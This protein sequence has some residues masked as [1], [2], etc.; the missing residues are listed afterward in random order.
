MKRGLLGTRGG[1]SIVGDVVVTVL[2][3]IYPGPLLELAEQSSVL[4][5]Q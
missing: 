1:T 4:I 5:A 3:G 2:L